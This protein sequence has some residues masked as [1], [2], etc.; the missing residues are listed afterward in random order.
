MAKVNKVES[1]IENSESLEK[2]WTPILSDE[3]DDVS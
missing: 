1:Q 3:G 2:C